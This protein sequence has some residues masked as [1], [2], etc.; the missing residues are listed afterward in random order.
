MEN[1]FLKKVN[2]GTTNLEKFQKKFLK[3]IGTSAFYS[4]S[5]YDDRR[6]MNGVLM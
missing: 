5:I 3:N 2:A 4:L 6:D 1:Y